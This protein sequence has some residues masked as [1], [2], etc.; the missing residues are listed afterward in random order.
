M[1]L[2]E[3]AC[4]AVLVLRLARFFE[5][6]ALLLSTLSYVRPN[7][8]HS[9]RAKLHFVNFNDMIF[10]SSFLRIFSTVEICSISNLFVATKILSIK[11]CA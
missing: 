3:L 8:S 4:G 10:L 2:V 1:I 9:F 11:A 6:A 5:Q 7:I